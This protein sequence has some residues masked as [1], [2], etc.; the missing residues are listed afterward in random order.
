VPKAQVATDGEVL[1]FIE[2]NALAGTGL[3]Y[4]DVHLLAAA[5]ETNP[6]SL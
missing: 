4:I 2:A 1:A 6:A 3:G 5:R